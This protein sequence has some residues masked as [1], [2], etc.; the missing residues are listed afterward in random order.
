MGI[1]SAIATFLETEEPITAFQ[2]VQTYL[3][4]MV[5]F[6]WAFTIVNVIAAH[7]VD[8]L[9]GCDDDAE[10]CMRIAPD[11]YLLA[12]S[13]VVWYPMAGAVVLY[14]GGGALSNHVAR[15]L[16]HRD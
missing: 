6:I 4:F 12:A 2:A 14:L 10:T 11:L 5:T 3:V 1:C 15:R 7:W 13:E 9:R 8:M 16:Q